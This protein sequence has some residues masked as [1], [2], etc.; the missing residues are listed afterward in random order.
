MN[1]Y[2][3][4]TKIFKNPADVVKAEKKNSL[5]FADKS[6]LLKIEGYK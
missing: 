4:K 3:K 1:N 6:V 5:D 2:Q